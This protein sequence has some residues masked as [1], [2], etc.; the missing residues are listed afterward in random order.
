MTPAQCR[1]ARGLLLWSQPE[2]AERSRVSVRAIQ[3]LERGHTDA[4]PATL[5]ALR[6]AFEGAGVIFIESNGDGPGVRLREP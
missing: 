6:T 4:F 3:N 5:L 2:L 1:A